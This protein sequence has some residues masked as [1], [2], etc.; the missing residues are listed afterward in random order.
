VITYIE[1][2]STRTHYLVTC[3]YVIRSVLERPRHYSQFWK[4]NRFGL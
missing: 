4:N 3:C 2:I 1:N